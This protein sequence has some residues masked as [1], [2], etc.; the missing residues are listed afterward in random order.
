MAK[1]EKEET[2]KEKYHLSPT[3]AEI[4][5]KLW[6]QTEPIKQTEL[7]A[8]FNKE[9]KDWGRQTLNTLLLRLEERGFVKREKRKVWAV[10]DQ[11]GFGV[12]IMEEAADNFFKG[13]KHKL[14][15]AFAEKNLS[16]EQA[17]DLQKMIAEYI[18][19]QKEN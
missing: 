6:Q 3:E 2:V 19:A 5:E 4:M 10:Y 1:M 12:Q 16:V 11:E 9:G 15:A 18:D 13:K 7:L 17:K 8:M 14:F